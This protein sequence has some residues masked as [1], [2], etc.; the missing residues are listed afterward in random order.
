MNIIGHPQTEET[1]KK[2]GM[3]NAIA[4]KGKIPW[5]KGIPSSRKGIPW[6]DSEREAHR[7]TVAKGERNHFW[8]GGV[9][10]INEALRKSTEYRLWRKAVY[11][12]DKYT[13][14]WCGQIGGKLHPDHIKP[15]SLY[16]ELRFA[17]DNGRTLCIS[18]HKKTETYGGKMNKKEAL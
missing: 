12:R 4:L 8:K 1:R 18:C 5:N 7:N 9:T 10:S 14:I 2:I 6:S 16:P 13:C 17:I 15:W 11:E 3:A